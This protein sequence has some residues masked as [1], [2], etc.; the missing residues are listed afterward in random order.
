[1]KDTYKECQKKILQ[2]MKT[3]RKT[4]KEIRPQKDGC[5]KVEQSGTEQKGSE[6]CTGSQGPPWAVAPRVIITVLC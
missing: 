2:G 1:M 5:P 3:K 4:K 6:K